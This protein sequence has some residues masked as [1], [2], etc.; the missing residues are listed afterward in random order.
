MKQEPDKY[1]VRWRCECG[2]ILVRHPILREDGRMAW[3]K[4]GY[5]TFKKHRCVPHRVPSAGGSAALK[6]VL[7]KYPDAGDVNLGPIPKNLIDKI[8]KTSRE[9]GEGNK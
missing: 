8:F 5:M 1:P 9:G 7:S 4:D 6:E 3:I 2:I